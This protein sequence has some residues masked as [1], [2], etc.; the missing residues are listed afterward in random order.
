MAGRGGCA[1][2]ALD[3]ALRPAILYAV[4]DL[5]KQVLGVFSSPSLPSSADTSLQASGVVRDRYQIFWRRVH[6]SNHYN[7]PS[8]KMWV[9]L[10]FVVYLCI[11]WQCCYDSKCVL[12]TY[13]LMWYWAEL[14]INCRKSRFFGTHWNC[15][16]TLGVALCLHIIL[17]EKFCG[18]V[19]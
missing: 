1:V 11:H 7:N 2:E 12:K 8:R 5:H 10:L 13:W 16:N 18:K 3:W 6:S 4:S 17:V 9:H 15:M 14:I 19:I